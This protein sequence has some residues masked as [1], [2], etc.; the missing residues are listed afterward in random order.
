MELVCEYLDPDV[1]D[2]LKTH[3]PRP[4]RGQNYH[5]WLSEQYGLK[6]LTEHIW[7]LIGMASTC[8][9]M[10]ELKQK[11]AE[12]FGRVPVQYTLFIPGEVQDQ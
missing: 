10:M 6:R 1:A 3:A 5:Q 9:S 7:M 8:H 2:W 11:L 12:R 4:T